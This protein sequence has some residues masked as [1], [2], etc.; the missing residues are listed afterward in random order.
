MARTGLTNF[1]AW[2]F[3]TMFLGW[4]LLGGV[5]GLVMLAAGGVAVAWWTRFWPEGL[6]VAAGVAGLLALNGLLSL[7]FDN[8]GAD[9]AA[10][11]VLAAAIVAVVTAIVW[12]L[13]LD[14]YV[15][16]H[17]GLASTDP[18]ALPPPPPP[19]A[20][21]PSVVP[22]SPPA[23]V[24]NG[25]SAPARLVVATLLASFTLLV[26]G[27]FLTMGFGFSCGSDTTQATPGS[28]HAAHCDLFD[29]SGHLFFLVVVLPP[30]IVFM[31]GLFA[32]VRRQPRY[33]TMA[34]TIGF[35]LMV[36]IHL[37]DWFLSNSA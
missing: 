22:P 36:A 16:Y 19:G 30:A 29:N 14:A 4:A 15:E 5:G 27:F 32:A 11:E 8:S 21:T 7:G 17:S 23:A 3:A 25:H 2:A 31:M 13:R 9:R 1:V 35:A 24:A 6:G 34:V 33:V 20:P 12:R 37:P 18:D 26:V 28:P 10:G